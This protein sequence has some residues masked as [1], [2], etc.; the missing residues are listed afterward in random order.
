LTAEERKAVKENRSS[1]DTLKQKAGFGMDVDLLFASM[2]NAAGF[3]VRMARV[4]DRGDA[5]FKKSLPTTY[6]PQNFNVAVK[7]NDAWTFFDPATPYL[8]Q[9]TR[10]FAEGVHRSQMR[11]RIPQPP[12][13]VAAPYLNRPPRFELD[14]KAAW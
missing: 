2:A 11:S 5:F 3:E 1:G 13:T 9:G 6:F 8:E 14:W 7:V 12:L 4:P 10:T